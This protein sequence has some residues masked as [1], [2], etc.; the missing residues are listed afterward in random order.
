MLDVLFG[1]NVVIQRLWNNYIMKGM[2]DKSRQK[3]SP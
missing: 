3:K 1:D 2:T